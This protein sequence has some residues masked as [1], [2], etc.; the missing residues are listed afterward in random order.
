MTVTE[1][2]PWVNLLL[3]PA[4][5]LLGKITNQLATLTAVQREHDRRLTRLEERAA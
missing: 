3:V 4:V 2:L 1:I 5:V